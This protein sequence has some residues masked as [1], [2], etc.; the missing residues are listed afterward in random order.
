MRD[1]LAVAEAMAVFDW[2]LHHNGDAVDKRAAQAEQD[3][4]PGDHHAFDVQAV[5]LARQMEER[6]EIRIVA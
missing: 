6:S 1:R 3:L 4:V 5:L 2:R